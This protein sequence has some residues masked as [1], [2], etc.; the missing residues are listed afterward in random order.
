VINLSAL[1]FGLFAKAVAPACVI[2][3]R[4][5]APSREVLIYI[6]PK[7]TGTID[8]EFRIAFDTLDVQMVPLHQAV[9]D[10]TVW[11][12]LMWG[13]TRDANLIRYLSTFDSLGKARSRGDVVSREGF[14][15]GDRKRVRPETL[16]A[17]VLETDDFPQNTHKWLNVGKLPLNTD[18]TFHSRDSTDLSA[19][20]APQLLI[21]QGWQRGSQR[22][23]AA[24][25]RKSDPSVLCSSSYVSVHAP[26]DHFELLERAWFAYN[27]AIAVYYLFR[28]SPR[29]ASYRPE[30]TVH[31]L[32][33]LPLPPDPAMSSSSRAN[34]DTSIFDAYGLRES[35]VAL[36][37]D[38]VDVTLPE[39]A[40]QAPTAPSR[41]DLTRYCEFLI[42]VLE[43]A[44]GHQGVSATIFRSDHERSPVQLVEIHLGSR[45]HSNVHIS[46]LRHTELLFR[47]ARVVHQRENGS[48]HRLPRLAPKVVH[49]YQM[50]TIDGKPTPT[51][52][53]LKPSRLRYWLR[54]IAM[55]DGDRIANDILMWSELAPQ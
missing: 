20:D 11:T 9:T 27:S 45:K 40:G 2:V 15:R 43:S 52:L 39:F 19:F 49:S 24:L 13:D 31:D 6:C 3:A 51:V 54:S 12:T 41:D 38:L 48:H 4:P 44:F 47:S 46:E 33:S 22:L 36:I 8:D 23:R 14:I 29:L 17:K 10:A 1:R 30:P 28:T 16:T 5:T 35:D 7:P 34:I 53:I 42:R 55:R 37:E 50:T 26:A 21:K 18:P 25:T 32:L